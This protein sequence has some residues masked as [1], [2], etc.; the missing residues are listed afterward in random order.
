MEITL[1]LFAGI[2]IIL[3]YLIL[4]K[5]NKRIRI[6]MSISTLC[7]SILIFGGRFLFTYSHIISFFSTIWL[8]IG[9]GN[10]ISL[11]WDSS[12]KRRLKFDQSPL[13][14]FHVKLIEDY[15]SSH[16]VYKA[17]GLINS[18][19]GDYKITNYNQANLSSYIKLLN[20]SPELEILPSVYEKTYQNISE[21][22]LNPICQLLNET[23]KSLIPERIALHIKLLLE[24]KFCYQLNVSEFSFKQFYLTN[25][26]QDQDSC[27][28]RIFVY[29]ENLTKNYKKKMI[30]VPDEN[31][32]ISLIEWIFIWHARFN[33][34]LYMIKRSEADKIFN[35]LK[36]KDFNFPRKT[37]DFSV[38]YREK[39]K[40]LIVVI[41]YMR[42]KIKDKDIGVVKTPCYELS[43]SQDD[44]Y[45]KLYLALKDKSIKLTDE[46]FES[47]ASSN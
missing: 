17:K 37:Y 40:K 14:N 1:N 22:I 2:L 38:N 8:V 23:N 20:K 39:D 25:Y 21:N 47:Y 15:L 12:I 42:E 36:T 33:I 29:T 27:K 24:E 35:K 26:D 28:E 11:I 13:Y 44:Q 16:E 43:L 32:H 41:N 46:N 34:D 18:N 45:K 10:T 6:T 9:L 7:V 19:Y 30:Y 5:A 3:N 4:Y 31:K